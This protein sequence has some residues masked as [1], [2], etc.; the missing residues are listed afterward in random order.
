M[1]RQVALAAVASVVA[2]CEEGP[3]PGRPCAGVDCSLHGQCIDRSGAALCI[4]DPGYHAVFLACVRDDADADGD[5]D[6]DADGTEEGDAEPP[7]DDLGADDTPPDEPGAEDALPDEPGAEDALPDEPGA[8]DAPLDERGAEDALVDELGADDTSPDERG[9]EDA[10]PDELGPE[11]APPDEPGAGDADDAEADAVDAEA[12]A[13]TGCWIGGTEYEA[14]ATNPADGCEWCQPGLSATGWSPRPDFTPCTLTTVPDRSYDICV[15]G[16]CVSP[17]CS[18]PSCDPPGPNFDL[19]DTNQR[20]CYD[21]TGPATC[22]GAAGAES[23]AATPFCGQDAQYGWDTRYPASAR[24]GRT[25]PVSGHP[26]V[27]DNVTG[28]V[29]Q[30]CVAGL[31]GGACADGTVVL[32][33]W[34]GAVDYCEMLSWGGFDDW[35]LPDRF[36]LHSIVDHGRALPAID[37][38][39]FPATPITAAWT[40]S[41]NALSATHAWLVDFGIGFVGSTP[42]GDEMSVR[43]V[44]APAGARLAGER[45]VRTEPVAGEPVVADLALGVV[46]QGCAWAQRGTSCADQPAYWVDW[47]WALAH[48]E[49]L[50]WGGFTDWYLPD[51]RQLTA[52]MDDHSAVPPIDEAVFPNTPLGSSWSSTSRA[53]EPSRAWRTDFYAGGMDDDVKDGGLGFVRCVRQAP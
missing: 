40:L 27:T 15:H 30:G 19:P 20:S 18:D 7:L 2:G 28:L 3:V 46:W 53:D 49:G 5:A 25:E 24:F 10:P 42:E 45:F 32:R 26:V 31:G 35:R 8:D 52:L 43:C 41:S 39:A 23:C 6:L 48:C 44:R 36:E 13:A 34:A 16:T 12:E 50:D 38:A 37:V 1:A 51:A 22:P 33:G 21:A 14:G 17:G 29:W 11:D 4:C 47:A 9:A